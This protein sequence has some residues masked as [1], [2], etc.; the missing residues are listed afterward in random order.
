VSTLEI[1]LLMV[2]VG[3]LTAVVLAVVIYFLYRRIR[4]H[5]VL[6]RIQDL[7]WRNRLDLAQRLLTDREIP[8][9]TRAILV[10]L[11]IYL[12]LPID[13]IPDF[14]PIIGWIDDILI[15]GGGLLLFA[16]LVPR[17]RLDYHIAAVSDEAK[18]AIDVEYH[19]SERP[20]RV[21]TTH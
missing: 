20:K 17:E 13:L 11:T 15:L 18:D 1:V 8:L 7:S 5:P 3:L 6:T 4:V 16:R 14:I 2:L 21:T 12:A 9:A 10:V 19:E